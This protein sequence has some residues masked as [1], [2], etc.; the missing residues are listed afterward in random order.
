MKIL[1]YADVDLNLTDGS[2]I[3]LSSLCEVLSMD[4]LFQVHVLLKSAVKKNPTS[5]N[6]WVNP[7][8]HYKSFPFKDQRRL[9][10]EEALTLLQKYDTEI[11][12]DFIV[13]RQMRFD[14]LDKLP[15][16]FISRCFLY[17]LGEENYQGNNREIA[18]KLIK[19]TAGFFAQTEQ[20]RQRYIHFLGDE[21]KS[22]FYLMTPMIPD[23]AFPNDVFVRNKES[24]LVYTGKF[25]A[26]WYIREILDAVNKHENENIKLDI[27]GDKFHNDVDKEAL[28]KQF[29]E[30]PNVKWHGRLDRIESMALINECDVG[31]GWRNPTMDDSLEI[32]TKFLECSMMGKPVLL[33]STPLYRELLGSDYPLFVDTPQSFYNKA[34][35]V[36]TDTSVY[37]DAARRCYNS[38]TFFGYRN[39]LT[40]LR[41]TFLSVYW[42]KPVYITT[43]KKKLRIVFAG[44]DLRFVQFF[45]D[46]LIQSDKYDIKIDKFK[47]HTAHDENYSRSLIDWADV[48]FCEWGL[49]N[50]VWYSNNKKSNQK[51]IVRMHLQEADTIHPTK[52]NLFEIDKF[53][54]IAPAIYEKMYAKFNFPRD[55]MT[56]IWNPIDCKALDVPKQNGVDY[57]I[58]MMGICPQRKRVDLALDI[59]E[60]LLSYDNRYRLYIKGN[61]PEEYK[62][63]WNQA[64]E[65][66]YYNKFYNRIK[67]LNK[68][69]IFSPYDSNISE[70][71]SNIGF[72]L[73]VSDFE[74]SH[75]VVAEA[76][77][78]GT[79]PVIR[80]WEGAGSIY[81]VEHVFNTIDEMVSFIA[82]GKHINEI[83]IKKY[84]VDNFDL[85]VV[86]RKLEKVI[87]QHYT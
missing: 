14:L 63:L 24:R 39:A 19:K 29:N 30:M 86:I 87:Q 50:A 6:V 71:F 85:S 3:W 51:L 4:P 82:K 5:N 60:Q 10:Q 74:G 17:I 11:N 73:S 53:V 84:A 79:I 36:C 52:F 66:T 15:D 31:I 61:R 80:N 34:R 42:D 76:M 69:V 62:W 38:A 20:M 40:R 75:Q 21:N 23:K 41:E 12:A 67:N 57:N 7:F 47:N 55:K 70:W 48:I 83:T 8:T 58:G 72:L 56:L 64:T 26:M 49:G 16:S 32:S 35:M 13:M 44:H 77:A 37:L 78:A 25:S 81:P 22:R 68:K 43:V 54:F 46:Y 33:N 65:R 18:L 28:I 1:I 27:A 59:L 45:I 9:A 2:A